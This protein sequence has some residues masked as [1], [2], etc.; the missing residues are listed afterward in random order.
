MELLNVYFC[1]LLDRIIII[2]IIIITCILE[3]ASLLEQTAVTWNILY[4]I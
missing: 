2:I 4:Y 1:T 3:K